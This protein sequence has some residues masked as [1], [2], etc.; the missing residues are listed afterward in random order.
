MAKIFFVLHLLLFVSVCLPS[1]YIL[2]DVY[3][4]YAY[5]TKPYMSYLNMHLCMYGYRKKER[6]KTKQTNKN[7]RTNSIST[8][9]DARFCLL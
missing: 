3:S 1:Y 4:S 2:L 6:K 5:S 9:G 7:R 8:Y